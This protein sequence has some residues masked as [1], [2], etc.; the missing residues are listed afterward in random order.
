MTHIRPLPAY[1][2]QRFHGW[3]ATTYQENRAWY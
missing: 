3:R 2:I 1:L